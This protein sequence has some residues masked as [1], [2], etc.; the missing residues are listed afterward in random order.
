M[1]FDLFSIDDSK[2]SVSYCHL[3]KRD[4]VQGK[5]VQY[6][7]KPGENSTHFHGIV[8]VHIQQQMDIHDKF[9]TPE[10]YPTAKQAREEAAKLAYSSIV[11]NT[12][13]LHPCMDATQSG[14]I[15]SDYAAQSFLAGKF[16]EAQLLYIQF[17]Y[18][19]YSI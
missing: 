7:V 19:L 4:L 14:P 17:F 5:T 2:L 12:C 13:M 6:Q 10:S 18:V 11:A 15:P 1:C 8:T 9:E 16:I 3:L